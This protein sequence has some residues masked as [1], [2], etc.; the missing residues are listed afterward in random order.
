ML[1]LSVVSRRIADK[2]TFVDWHQVSR[3]KRYLVPCTFLDLYFHWLFGVLVPDLLI[4][5]TE[6]PGTILSL[7]R[8]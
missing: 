3:A 5:R 7:Q 1:H 8:R 6:P 2:S 4:L